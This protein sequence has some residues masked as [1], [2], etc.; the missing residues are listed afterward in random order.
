MDASCKWC[1]NTSTMAHRCRQGASTP[2]LLAEAAVQNRIG[3][4][5]ILVDIYRK[6]GTSAAGGRKSGAERPA[7]VDDFRSATSA[8]GSERT[9][10][11]KIRL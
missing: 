8:L 7:W 5:R 1:F 11:V 2:T 3:E 6:S 9:D 10:D 4:R